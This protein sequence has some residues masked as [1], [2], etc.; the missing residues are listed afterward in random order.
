MEE[1]RRP[2]VVPT[3]NSRLLEVIWIAVLPEA[4]QTKKV[5]WFLWGAAFF[6]IAAAFIVPN[7]DFSLQEDSPRADATSDPFRAEVHELEATFQQEGLVDVDPQRAVDHA[8]LLK[9]R[10]LTRIGSM[11]AVEVIDVADTIEEYQP[12]IA[13][14]PDAARR[15]TMRNHR[16]DLIF[17]E[18]HRVD[19]DD[20][21]RLF[22]EIRDE[23]IETLDVDPA[24]QQQIPETDSD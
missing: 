6:L 24:Y 13:A 3:R 17:D 10:A 23:F 2:F 5:S 22:D 15:V 8:P 4:E 18:L 9:A 19:K 1:R 20:G 7:V 16:N 21:V 14:Q 12:Q 11:S